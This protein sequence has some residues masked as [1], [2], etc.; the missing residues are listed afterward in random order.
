MIVG[1]TA[2]SAISLLAVLV[3]SMVSPVPGQA[4]GPDYWT[5][6]EIRLLLTEGTATFEDDE[7]SEFVHAI[8]WDKTPLLDEAT[9]R[10]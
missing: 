10:N 8:Q 6:N 4:D 1:R 7:A 3:L 5:K 9:W 2:V